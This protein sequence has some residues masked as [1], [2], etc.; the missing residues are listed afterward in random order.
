MLSCE[1]VSFIRKTRTQIWTISFWKHGKA[2]QHYLCAIP[3][4]RLGL[5]LILL[6]LGVSS[7]SKFWGEQTWWCFCSVLFFNHIPFITAQANKD[8]A[9]AIVYCSTKLKIAEWWFNNNKQL[10]II[11]IANDHDCE[12]N[13]ISIRVSTIHNGFIR[14]VDF[15][16]SLGQRLGLALHLHRIQWEVTT[17][18]Q[19]QKWPEVSGILS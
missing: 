13:I 18:V 1:T 6:D 9:V 12:K 17:K 14:E 3:S 2:K 11:N 8:G 16:F 4:Y 15:R 10:S 5:R 19:N 7:L